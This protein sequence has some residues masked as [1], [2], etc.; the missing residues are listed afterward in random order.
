VGHASLNV[1][2]VQ[3]LIKA[4]GRSKAF[5]HLVGCFPKPTLP[6]LTSHVYSQFIGSPVC[7]LSR[8]ISK[9]SPPAKL[10]KLLVLCPLETQPETQKFDKTVRV[11]LVKN[12]FFLEGGVIGLVE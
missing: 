3:P 11:A 9:V 8:L 4:D 6:E 2:T 10:A 12:C 7:R 5:N 1:I